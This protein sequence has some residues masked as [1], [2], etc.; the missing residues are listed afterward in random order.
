MRRDEVLRVLREHR[1][2]LAQFR[3]TSL[4]LFGSVARDEAGAHS[5]VDLLVEFDRPAGLLNYVGLQQHLEGL[6]GVR[7]DL[8]SRN[9]LRPEFRGQVLSEAID[10]A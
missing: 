3:V 5:D 6:L 1:H 8:V 2:E 9:A 10:A 4:A 7:V